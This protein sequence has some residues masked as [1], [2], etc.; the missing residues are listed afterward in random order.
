MFGQDGAVFVLSGF[1]N[2][3]RSTLCSQALDMVA[4]YRPD[5]TSDCTLLV[6]AFANTP[7]FR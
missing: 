7:K 3:E 6:C 4:E 1:M 2:P 5:W